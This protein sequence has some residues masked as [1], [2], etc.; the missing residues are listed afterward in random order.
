VY[1]GDHFAY[2][3]REG[4]IGATDVKLLGDKS[5]CFLRTL[6]VAVRPRFARDVDA[7]PEDIF[8]CDATKASRVI[9]KV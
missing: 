1:V 5:I 8:V 9:Q 4:A 6:S 2:D 3:G 7:D